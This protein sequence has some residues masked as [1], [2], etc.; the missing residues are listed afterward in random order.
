LLGRWSFSLTGDI[1][2]APL[3]LYTLRDGRL[4]YTAAGP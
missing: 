3:H 1:I 4:A 2:P